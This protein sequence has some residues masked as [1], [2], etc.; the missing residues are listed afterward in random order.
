MHATLS[1]CYVRRFHF[2]NH[3]LF[4]F[5]LKFAFVFHVSLMNIIFNLLFENYLLIIAPVPVISQIP[6]GPLL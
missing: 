3:I 1:P 5:Y 2:F 4:I 6:V